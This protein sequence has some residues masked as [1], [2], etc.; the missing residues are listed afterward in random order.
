MMCIA[1]EQDAM[2]FAYLRRKGLITPDGYL[3][4]PP[5]SLTDPV[6]TVPAPAD[7]SAENASESADKTSGFSSDDPTAQ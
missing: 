2:W 7:T 3:V 4:E 6:D 5:P 1:C